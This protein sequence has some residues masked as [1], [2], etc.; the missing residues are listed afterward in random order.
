[1][2]CKW[3]NAAEVSSLF[4]PAILGGELA[5][6]CTECAGNR[7]PAAEQCDLIHTPVM[8]AS[9]CNRGR[10]FR[11]EGSEALL[12]GGYEMRGL[13]SPAPNTLVLLI[14]LTWKKTFPE[15]HPHLGYLDHI[16]VMLIQTGSELSEYTDWHLFR[17]ASTDGDSTNLEV[18]TSSVTSLISKCVDVTAFKTITS[19]CYN[20]KLWMTAEV[21]ELLK[22]RD[23]AFRKGDKEAQRNARAKLSRAHSGGESTATYRPQQHAAHM[24]G[25]LFPPT[26]KCC[27]CPR[28]M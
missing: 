20:Q 10:L 21:C 22:L 3:Y 8:C 18:Y 27:A 16:S 19:S 26:N 14:L 24:A 28:Q 13:L 15:P 25:H 2:W 6:R 1:M 4:C 17:E 9:K 11:E 12:C 5:S 7:G 23:F